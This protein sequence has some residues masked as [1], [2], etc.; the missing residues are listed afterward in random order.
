MQVGRNLP[1]IRA[2]ARS[3]FIQLL[4]G[5]EEELRILPVEVPC[6]LHVVVTKSA[7]L[8]IELARAPD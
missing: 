3:K 7:C 1:E 5:D 6:G 4:R 8:K 2:V